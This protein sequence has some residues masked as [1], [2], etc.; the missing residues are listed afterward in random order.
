MLL[1]DLSDAYQ[2]LGE[3]IRKQLSHR[4]GRPALQAFT[5]A[6]LVF[7][8]LK[9]LHRIDKQQRSIRSQDRLYR[10]GTQRGLTGCINF[11]LRQQKIENEDQLQVL[12]C[13]NSEV[14]DLANI[15][16][17]QNLRFIDLRKNRISNLTPLER[18]DR[19]S[20]L[21]LSDNLIEDISP[22]L[23]IQT[24]RS[25]NL[26]GNDSIPCRDVAELTRRLGANFTAPNACKR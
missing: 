22:L 9:P 18:L 13:A 23:R 10:R 2:R 20:G 6:L 19:L 25:L 3:P 24:L 7:C 26:A 12:A 4:L 16:R 1:R 21:N 5:F 15:S 14:A 11:A 8:V 17:L